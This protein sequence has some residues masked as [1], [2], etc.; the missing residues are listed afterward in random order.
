M[1]GCTLVEAG[2]FGPD[3]TTVQLNDAACDG[4]AEAQAAVPPGH[5]I[6]DL[7][8]VLEDVVKLAGGNAGAA[9]AHVD[10]RL[11][12]GRPHADLNCAAR[13]READGVVQEV[14]EY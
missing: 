11:G 8:I 4:E 14:F 12:R 1:Q 3:A 7:V 2:A 9:V 10:L 13:R 5:V 6:L